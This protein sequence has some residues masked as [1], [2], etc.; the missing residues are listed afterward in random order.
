VTVPKTRSRP[1]LRF[2]ARPEL[3]DRLAVINGSAHDYVDATM[4]EIET[5]PDGQ[6]KSKSFIQAVLLGYRPAPIWLVIVLTR[7]A[8][9]DMT[10]TRDSAIALA[11]AWFTTEE[12][13][14][15]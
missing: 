6:V 1:T 12:A 9:E 8:E 2:S 14:R 10:L 13:D 4:R 5:A 11:P 3:R 15:G 7:I